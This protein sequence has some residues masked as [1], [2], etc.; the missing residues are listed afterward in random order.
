MNLLVTTD[1]GHDAPGFIELTRLARSMPKATVYTVAPEDNCSG[2]GTSRTLAGQ[3][4]VVRT[5]DRSWTVDGTPVDCVEWALRRSSRLLPPRFDAALSGINYGANAG[6][7]TVLCSGTVGAA[8]A[9]AARGV[10]AMAISQ[11]VR[12]TMRETYR[13]DA[14]RDILEAWLAKLN[15]VRPRMIYNVNLPCVSRAMLGTKVVPV[16]GGGYDGMFKELGL[17]NRWKFIQRW[18]SVPDS[19]SDVG[20]LEKGYAVISVIGLSKGEGR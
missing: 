18:Q 13:V 8:L 1:D 3:L 7:V 4:K 9:A 16:G 15:K 11:D 10:P 17:K 20:L 5:G 2:C 6:M 19:V 12:N 14:A